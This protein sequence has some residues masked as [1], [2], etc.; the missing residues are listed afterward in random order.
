VALA[1]TLQFPGH[2]HHNHVLG[3]FLGER[4]GLPSLAPISHQHVSISIQLASSPRFTQASQQAGHPW[5]SPDSI[6]LT[7]AS[8]RLCCAPGPLQYAVLQHRRYCSRQGCAGGVSSN[9]AVPRIQWSYLSIRYLFLETDSARKAASPDSIT[10]TSVAA[11][12]CCPP[13]P[14]QDAAPR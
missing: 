9:S 4:P 5:P 7:L 6:T 13:G 14:L 1:S 11:R 3:S 2:D 8:A 10:L 12:L